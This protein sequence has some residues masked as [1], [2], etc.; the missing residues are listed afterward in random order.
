MSYFEGCRGTARA[1][2]STANR[3][4]CC[5]A[6]SIAIGVAWTD[7]ARQSRTWH[8]NVDK[9]STLIGHV[10]NAV[11]S[12]RYDI[13]WIVFPCWCHGNQVMPKHRT[14]TNS[15]ADMSQYKYYCFDFD[16]VACAIERFSFGQSALFPIANCPMPFQSRLATQSKWSSHVPKIVCSIQKPAKRSIATNIHMYTEWNNNTAKKS[17]K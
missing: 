16:F 7:G 12:I 3:H 8:K 15:L 14:Q 13:I 5:R 1:P 11:I 6:S 4:D 2:S 10:H 17:L 9:V